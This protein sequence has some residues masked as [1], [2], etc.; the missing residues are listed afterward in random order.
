MR[1]PITLSDLN[2]LAYRIAK[3]EGWGESFEEREARLEY[4]AEAYAE[5][6]W[7]RHAERPDPEAEYD[8]ALF[9]F[10]HPDGYGR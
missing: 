7:L 10:L 1:E 4:E 6:G 9:D 5:N 3:A 8:L 2:F